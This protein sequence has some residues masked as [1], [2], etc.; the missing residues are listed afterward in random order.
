MGRPVKPG[1]PVKGQRSFPLRAVSIREFCALYGIS[2]STAWRRIS[3][4]R[5][6]TMALSPGGKRLILL[7]GLEPPPLT[8]TSAA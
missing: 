4:G 1:V 6:R 5:L 7:E 2:P 8:P 3:E